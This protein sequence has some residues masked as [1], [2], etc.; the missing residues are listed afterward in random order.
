MT[1]SDDFHRNAVCVL[2]SSI[3]PRPARWPEE[4]PIPGTESPGSYRT[5]F[6][7]VLPKPTFLSQSRVRLPRHAHAM[8]SHDSGPLK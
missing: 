1:R 2:C 6:P 7:S 4:P 3:I 5:L 8:L